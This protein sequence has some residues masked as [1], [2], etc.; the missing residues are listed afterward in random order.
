[1]IE[2]GVGV[3]TA[4]LSALTINM[5]GTVNETKSEVV[6]LNTTV[7]SFQPYVQGQRDQEQRLTKL[8]TQVEQLL[9]DDSN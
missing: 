3:L 9:E 1:M 5:I 7:S 4:T 6:R 2:I 8:E